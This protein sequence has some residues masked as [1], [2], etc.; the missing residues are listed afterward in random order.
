[1]RYHPRALLILLG[2]VPVVLL[3]DLQFLQLFVDIASVVAT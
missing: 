2:I 1:M 3:I